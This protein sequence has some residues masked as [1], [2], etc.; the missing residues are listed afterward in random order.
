MKFLDRNAVKSGTNY[1]TFQ[2]L[3]KKMDEATRIADF[4]T[5]ELSVLS[6]IE[7]MDREG[8]EYI[9][10]ICLN[11]GKPYSIDENGPQLN[12]VRIKKDKLNKFLYD[13]FKEVKLLLYDNSLHKIFW[14]SESFIKTIA[15]V[16]KIKGDFFFKPGFARNLVLAGELKKGKSFPFLI[17]TEDNDT[18]IIGAV[19]GYFQKED[20]DLIPNIIELLQKDLGKLSGCFWQIDHNMVKIELEFSKFNLNNDSFSPVITICTSNI[21]ESAFH[22]ALG[23]KSKDDFTIPIFKVTKKHTNVIKPNEVVAE[24]LGNLN[25]FLK[26]DERL[27]SLTVNRDMILYAK[28]CDLLNYIGKKKINYV[29]SFDMSSMSRENML[30]KSIDLINDLVASKTVYEKMGVLLG[31]LLMEK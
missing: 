14:V 16:L 28:N 23:I 8:N 7:E 27:S 29:F 20:A 5:D 13:E 1:L 12:K 6:Y 11:D 19:R 4:Y 31:K 24:L 9:P 17:R 3:L 10:L 22:C 26:V 2:S 15:Q 18:K 25:E 21:M 30:L